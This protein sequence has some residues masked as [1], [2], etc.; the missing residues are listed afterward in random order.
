MKFNK[1]GLTKFEDSIYKKIKEHENFEPKIYADHKGIPTLGVGYAILIEEEKKNTGKKSYR[2]KKNLDA[3]LGVKGIEKKLTK[4]D[5]EILNKVKDYLNWGQVREAEDLIEEDKFSISLTPAEGYKLFQTSLN[6][7]L[8][9]VKRQ[10]TKHLT[11]H[12]GKAKAPAEAEKL[13]NELENTR[14]MVT[15]ASLAFNAQTLIG[16]NLT[17]A[18][19]NGDRAAAWY[20][21]RYGSNAKDKKSQKRSFG[22]QNRRDKESENFGLYDDPNNVQE[23][24]A[25]NA[26]RFLEP[27]R[28]KIYQYLGEVKST[29]KKK[30]TPYSSENGQKEHLDSFLVKAQDKLNELYVEP[31]QKEKKKIENIIVDKFIKKKGDDFLSAKNNNAHLIFGEGGKDNITGKKGN[32]FLHGGEGNDTLKGNGG[33]DRIDGGEGKDTAVFSDKRENYK[34]SR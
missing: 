28:E 32:D 3:D 33:N 27:E 15:L 10:F 13:Y 21:I 14:E 25:K 26:I 16:P 7:A 4:E 12:V 22:L 31:Y 8:G 11:P 1:I 5:Y 2:F 17:K 18:L 9:A 19:Y 30:K 29:D 20:E 6:R 34:I 23:D 24:E